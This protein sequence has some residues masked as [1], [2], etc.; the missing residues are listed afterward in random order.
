MRELL[1]AP[2]AGLEPL[3]TLKELNDDCEQLQRSL[4][5][6]L[7]PQPLFDQKVDELKRLVTEYRSPA[8]AAAPKASEPPEPPAAAAPVR[9]APAAPRAAAAEAAPSRMWDPTE[10]DD[11]EDFTPHFPDEE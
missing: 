3:Y 10:D 6:G 1:N 4:A 11:L 5:L 9:P 7:I 2:P 8:A